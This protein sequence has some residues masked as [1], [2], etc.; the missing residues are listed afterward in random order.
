MQGKL[1]TAGSSSL[2]RG[3]DP[4]L[5]AE[6]KAHC[7]L[8]GNRVE[9]DRT[10][11]AMQVAKGAAAGARNPPSSTVEMALAFI[12]IAGNLKRIGHG[13]DYRS[14]V[15][16]QM[17][18]LD[19]KVAEAHDLVALGSADEGDFHLIIAQLLNKYETTIAS[20]WEAYCER[21]NRPWRDHAPWPT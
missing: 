5:L 13:R 10:W 18:R 19:A 14:R 8:V 2:A 3:V 1:A 7:V 17:D 6:V 9:I 21:Y 4:R 12:D 16:A 20:L 11:W 15:I